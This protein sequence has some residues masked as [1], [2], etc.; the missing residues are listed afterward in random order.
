[1]MQKLNHSFASQDI[2]KEEDIRDYIAFIDYI[3]DIQNL[4]E[5]LGSDLMSP[6]TLMQ[7]IDSELQK[8][9]HA[10][11]TEDLR[12]PFLKVFLDNLCLLNN[13]LKLLESNYSASCKVFSESFERLVQSARESIKAN[14]FEHVAEM[15]LIMLESAQALESHL[16]RQIEQKYRETVKLLMQHLSRFADKADPLLAKPHLSDSDVTKLRNDMEILR[17]AKENSALQDRISTYVE[18]LKNKT[19]VFEENFQDL[20]EI[21][22]KFIAKIVMYF[23]NISI[24]IQELLKENEDYALENIEQMVAEMEAIRTIPE[25][26]S[27]TAAAYYRTVENIRRYMQQLQKDAQKFLVVN[28]SQSENTNYRYL[29]KSLSRLKNAQWTDR[30]SPG[31]HHLFMRHIREELMQ[32]AHQLEDRLMKLDL[33]LKCHENVGVAQKILEQN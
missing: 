4:K 12:S 5:N 16:G 13:S 26:E 27:K 14:E 29:A 15:I 23:D 31:A 1:M 24:R 32:Y 18:M 7:S 11:K 8:R 3:K 17:S 19:D 10:L 2:L 28:D 20:N 9:I 25:L 21:Y 6:T 30:I 22:N 33:S